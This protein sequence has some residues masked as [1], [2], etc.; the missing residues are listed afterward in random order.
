MS[1]NTSPLNSTQKTVLLIDDDQ[2]TIETV[3]TALV[4]AGYKLL[5]GRD[6][7]EGLALAERELPDLIVVDLMMPRRSGF[8]VVEAVRQSQLAPT[9]II[10]IT[11]NDG[12]RHQT[13][14]EELG[15]DAY[16]LKPFS[17]ELLLKTVEKVVGD[18]T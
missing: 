4:S 5:I 11:G 16:L 13:Y 14:A 2:D 15:V 12:T 3:G 10:M 1:S 7:T 17:I 8:L 18:K 6:G 9:R